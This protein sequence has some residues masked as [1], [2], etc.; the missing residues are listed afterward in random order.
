M[1]LAH[2][3]SS[4]N[5]YLQT[6][7]PA[8]ENHPLLSQGDG[9]DVRTAVNDLIV[10]AANSARIWAELQHDFR[11]A[12]VKIDITIPAGGSVDL[13]DINGVAV[14]T[15][16][17][18]YLKD[19]KNPIR[20]ITDKDEFYRS[21][22]QDDRVG[23]AYQYRE[24][25]LVYEGNAIRFADDQDVDV[26]MTLV[27]YR[28]LP[29][30][31]TT[32]VAYPYTTQPNGGNLRLSLDVAWP[33][34]ITE[35]TIPYDIW[36]VTFVKEFDAG[37]YPV[38]YYSSTALELTGQAL[39]SDDVT[40]VAVPTL[41]VTS[42]STTTDWFINRGRSYMM[43]ATI[44]EV[45]HLLQTFVPRQEGSLNPPER[46]RESEFEALRQFDCFQSEGG[47]YQEL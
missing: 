17:A 22:E 25:V 40:G 2:L 3:I 44:V 34:G 18:V 26:D 4:V 35:V 13:D 45:N 36:S 5:S 8:V 11:C 33:L 21:Y 46:Q 41:Y 14:K 6:D 27:G 7:F 24:C 23:S 29:E 31:S 43:W 42:G 9:A 37:T 47:S 20:V 30:Y 1:T 28:W 38:T 39:A 10:K 15:I 19:S 16:T 12:S 32:N